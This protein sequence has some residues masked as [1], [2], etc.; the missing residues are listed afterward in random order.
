[1]KEVEARY[2][3]V[4]RLQRLDAMRKSWL[5]LISLVKKEKII[6]EFH[7]AILSATLS[8]FT[9][10]CCAQSMTIADR[11]HK[12]LSQVNL[13][14][15]ESLSSHWND[16]ACC[17]PPPPYND[18]PLKNKLLYVVGVIED[19]NGVTLE[20]CS[21]CSRNLSK[22]TIPKFA[23]ANR[24]YAGPVPEELWDLTTVAE[25]MI[26]CA[27]AKSW[28]VK[29]QEQVADT[30]APTAQRGLKG[31][32]IIYPQQPDQVANVLPPAIEETLAFTCVI[33]VGS[34][35]L[36]SAWLK[37]KAK[38][39]AVQWDKVRKALQWLKVNN[40]LYKNIEISE[41]NLNLL[42]VDDVLP[43]HITC[44]SG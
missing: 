18:G 31:H 16:P 10:A 13:D 4:E 37:E 40:P 8:L 33:F 15:L 24:L 7:L 27:R 35:A 11:V 1:M 25:C 3:A 12:K 43:Y 9:C 29:L 39:L 19:D 28:I 20:L 32:S 21:A 44:S 42:P 38:P 5:T 34:S 6:N 2:D 36:T 30:A 41:G 26:V 22:G 23:L 17:P 14:L